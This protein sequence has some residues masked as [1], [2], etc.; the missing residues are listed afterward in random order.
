[1][2]KAEACLWK[3]TLS[4]RQML[5]SGFRRQRPIGDFIVD[6]VCL[7]L[8][9]IIEVD[10]YS[11]HLRE[12]EIKDVRRQKE[13]EG[14]GYK[15]LR[16]SDEMVLKQMNQVKAIIEKQVLMIREEQAS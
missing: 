6:F 10:G 13:L 12:N 5:G 15:V 4:K 8:K 2:T 7:E 9:L 1:M 3:Y 14:M 16:F 11:H